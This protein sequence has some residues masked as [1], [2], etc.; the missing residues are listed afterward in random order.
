MRSP[1]TSLAAISLGAVLAAG[2]PAALA[3]PA[4]TLTI[5]HQ[6]RGCHAWSLNGGRDVVN[7]TLHLRAGGAL[8]VANFDLMPHRLLQLAGPTLRIRNLAAAT[9]TPMMPGMGGMPMM[10]SR[11][12]RAGMMN[13]MG[14][15]TRV[16]F[17]RPGLY[18]FT[19]KAGEDYMAGVRTVGPDNTLR[20]TVVVR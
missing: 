5:H 11:T 1:R 15:A 12:A 9:P 7:Q 20:L 16:V 3:G 14:A 6:L 10:G 18:R 17:A 19:T 4:A 2:A 13:G 8:T